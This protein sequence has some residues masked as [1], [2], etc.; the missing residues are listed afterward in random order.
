[1]S[2]DLRAARGAGAVDLF[3]DRVVSSL[4]RFVLDDSN[5][6]DV[7]DLCRRLDG[8]P[9]AIELAAAR[10]PMLGVAGVRQRLDERLRM[11]SAG[12]RSAPRRHQTLRELLD[13]SHG[14][15][16]DAERVVFR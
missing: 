1:E 8:L 3:V 4:P 15:L 7:V 12:A 10:V 16:S 11:L 9:L 2:A 5:V 14:L 13:W 6:A